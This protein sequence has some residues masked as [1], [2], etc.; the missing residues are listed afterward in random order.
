[1]EITLWMVVALAAILVTQLCSRYPN[2]IP[3]NYTKDLRIVT[4]ISVK[5][6]YIVS[7]VCDIMYLM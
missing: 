6:F 5:H 3:L 4:V 2:F 1:M 7:E